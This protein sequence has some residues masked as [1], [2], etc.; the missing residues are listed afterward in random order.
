MFGNFVWTCEQ[1]RWNTFQLLY[2]R[3]SV[4]VLPQHVVVA[5]LVVESSVVD[6]YQNVIYTQEEAQKDVEAGWHDSLEIK[7]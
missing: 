7:T 1:R 3:L 4:R 6:A 5:F 2:L